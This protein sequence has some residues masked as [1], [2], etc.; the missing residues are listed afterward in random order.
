MR[1][2]RMDRNTTAHYSSFEELAQAYG[3]KPF[4]K[5]TKDQEKLKEQR[6]RFRDKHRCKAC[7]EPM[8]WIM[9]SIMVCT[10]EKCKGIKVEKTDS[11]GNKSINYITSY[12]LLDEKYTERAKNIFS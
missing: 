8:E 11:E 5:Q 4:K 12:E 2:F 6:E 10:N 9:E 7:G 1:D 3:R